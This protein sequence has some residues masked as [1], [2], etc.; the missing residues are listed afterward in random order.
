MAGSNTPTVEDVGHWAITLTSQITNLGT[1]LSS[2]RLELAKGRV[3][4]WTTRRSSE[5][6]IAGRGPAVVGDTANGRVARW[7]TGR[8]TEPMIA[9]LNAAVVGDIGRCSI[10]F[11]S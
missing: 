2:R 7:I 9:G 5:P 4:K 10:T 1:A 8:S 6:K 3:G 11:A